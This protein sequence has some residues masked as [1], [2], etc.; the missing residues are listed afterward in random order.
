MRGGRS[1]RQ[2]QGAEWALSLTTSVS[3]GEGESRQVA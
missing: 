2:A 1:R 3:H